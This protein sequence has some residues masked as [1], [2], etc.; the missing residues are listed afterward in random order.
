M[1]VNATIAVFDVLLETK[2]VEGK[3]LLELK[4]LT[5]SKIYNSF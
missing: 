5:I 4:N 2:Y 3:T 1:V